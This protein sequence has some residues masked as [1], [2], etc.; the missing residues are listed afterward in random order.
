MKNCQFLR[1]LNFE[2]RLINFSI[3]A[4]KLSKIL[5]HFWLKNLETKTDFY[6]HTEVDI[7]GIEF[8]KYFVCATVKIS[9]K[10]EHTHLGFLK[11][12]NFETL[13]KRQL[14]FFC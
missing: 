8:Q 2:F 4:K 12:T 3:V 14:L 11:Q 7:A 13:Q 5:I 6:M 10:K 1:F 9:H